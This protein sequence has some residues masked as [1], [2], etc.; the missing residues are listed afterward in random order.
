VREPA[1]HEEEGGEVSAG[2]FMSG[3]LGEVEE[4]GSTVA[5]YRS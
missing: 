5:I 2:H 3:R 4:V 1:G